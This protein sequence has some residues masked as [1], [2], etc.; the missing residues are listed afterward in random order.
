MLDLFN[1]ELGD[2]GVAIVAAALAD[3]P[4]EHVYL[5]GNGAGPL[6][7]AALGE[8]FARSRALRSLD[9]STSGPRGAAAITR[10]ARSLASLALGEVGAARALDA[11]HNRIGDA[12]APAI[13]QWIAASSRLCALDLRGNGITSHRAFAIAAAVEQSASLV[14]VGLHHRVAKSIRRRI[15]AR[16]ARNGSAP[17][18]PAHVRAIVSVYRGKLARGAPS[19]M[20]S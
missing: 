7:A 18:L 14:A 19:G 10:G 17:A 20:L 4:I 6:A 11:K 2:A 9:V 13:A 5:G 8:L 16:L 3:S 15:R 12:G 1:C